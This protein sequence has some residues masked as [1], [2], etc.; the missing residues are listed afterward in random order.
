MTANKYS[1]LCTVKDMREALFKG[2]N[3]VEMEVKAHANTKFKDKPNDY[4]STR[5]P[6][7]IFKLDDDNYDKEL[8]NALKKLWLRLAQENG[9]PTFCIFLDAALR[10]MAAQKPKTLIELREL[11]GVNKRNAKLYGQIFLDEI[12]KWR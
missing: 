6:L 5:P 12:A 10:G 2:I 7:K 9:L 3:K 4:R 11:N 8:F 1:R